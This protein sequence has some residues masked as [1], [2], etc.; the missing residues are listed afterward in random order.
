[1]ILSFCNKSKYQFPPDLYGGYINLTLSTA[2]AKIF[3][4][5]L[6]FCNKSKYQFPPDLSGGYINLTL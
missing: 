2:L 6:S 1:M 4:L 3:L 5:I